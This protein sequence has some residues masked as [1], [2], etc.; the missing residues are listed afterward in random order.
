ML[1]YIPYSVVIV[2][3]VVLTNWNL[4]NCSALLFYHNRIHNSIKFYLISLY[5]ILCNHHLSCPFSLL[6]TDCPQFTAA[7]KRLRKGIGLRYLVLPCQLV[8]QTHS[9]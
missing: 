7:D 9:A 3:M 1:C 2:V 4:F 5:P 6:G 8:P